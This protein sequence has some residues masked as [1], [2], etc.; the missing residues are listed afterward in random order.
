MAEQR[1]RAHSGGV[2]KMRLPAAG[3]MEATELVQAASFNYLGAPSLAHVP[4]NRLM[5]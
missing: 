3:L 5:I 2:A 4:N 1:G